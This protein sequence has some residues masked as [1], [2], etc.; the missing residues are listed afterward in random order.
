MFEQIMK[1]YAIA[2]LTAFVTF[3]VYGQQPVVSSISKTFGYTGQSIEISGSGFSTTPSNLIV[4]FGAKNGTVISSTNNFIQ[5]TIPTGATFSSISVTHKVSGLTGFS[6]VKF[7]E[8]F[9]G[10]TTDAI[11]V[12]DRSTFPNTKELFDA[13]IIDLDE[14]GKNDVVASKVSPD[15]VDIVVYRNTTIGS[16]ISFSEQVEYIGNPTAKIG[17]GD[18][19]GDGKV[20]LVLSREG[21]GNRNQISILRN[22]SVSGTISF[23]AAKAYYLP[24]SHLARKVII[25]DMDFDG[26]SEVLVSNTFNNEIS[27][28]KNNSTAGTINLAF[29]PTIIAIDG[30]TKTNGMAVGDINNDGKEDIVVG[31][32]IANDIFVI[33]NESVDGNLIFGTQKTLALEEGHNIA[34][35]DLNLDGNLDILA[36]MPTKQTLAV[37]KNQGGEFNFDAPVILTTGLNGWD[38]GL[39]DYTG[40]GNVDVVVTASSGNTF[41]FYKNISQSGN[42]ELTLTKT[43]IGQT[44][45]TRNA[46]IGD[47]NGD[48][49]PELVMTTFSST[50]SELLVIRN[51]TCIESKLPVEDLTAQI[52]NGQPPYRFDVAPSPDA[53]FIWKK[54]GIEVKNSTDNFYDT[55]VAGTY[56]VTAVSE[57]GACTIESAPFDLTVTTGSI[58]ND[59]VAS[60]SGIACIGSST[61]LFSTPVTGATYLWTGPNGFTSTDQNPTLPSI[62]ADMAGVYSVIAEISPCKSAESTTI[63]EVITPPDFTIVL[64]GPSVLCEGNQISLTV[65]SEVGYSYQWQKDGVDI[66]GAT[67]NV[68]NSTGAGV[69]KAL[70]TSVSCSLSS[71]QVT[72]TTYSA[73]TPSFTTS[74]VLCVDT[75]VSFT[76]TTTLEAGQTPTYTWDFGDGTSSP[77]E[78]P[79][80][81]YTTAQD[82]TVT[83]AVDYVGQTCLGSTP[84]IITIAAPAALTLGVLAPG[85][86]PFC[87]GDSIELEASGDFASYLWSTT[88]T[89]PII[90]VKTADRFIVT[91]TSASGCITIDSIDITTNPQPVIIA[92]TRPDTVQLGQN[93]QLSATGGLSYVWSP[94]DGLDDPLIAEPIASLT[95]TSTYAVIGTDANGCEGTAEVTIVVQDSG[96]ELPVKAAVAFSPNGDGID[97][98]WLIEGIEN[99]PECELVIFDRSGKI[100]YKSQTTGYKND[101]NG[102]DEQGSQLPVGAYFYTISCTNAKTG[103]GSISIIR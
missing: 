30:A 66:A 15:A 36:T 46:A 56:T 84:Q 23:D 28:F 53:T 1:K 25:H 49:K 58:P 34:L 3:S 41:A 76:N 54:S 61:Q 67:T 82:Y 89:T 18:I 31:Q 64:G 35:V 50:S 20:D 38:I 2:I 48:A 19:D 33:P 11:S 42:I 65:A 12:A 27:I 57:S 26:K 83:L 55:D 78:N 68:I 21:S 85:A 95:L 62:T 4:N 43:D 9:P 60:N 86:I 69:Y 52:C 63:V 71:N 16:T 6:A 97:D 10:E 32:F 17:A 39:G 37:F 94:S 77:D 88:E 73:P 51:A 80:H 103:S 29:T 47:L 72:I 8:T 13:V 98:V 99:F 91:G 101:W 22:T 93:A 96:T 24:T 59:P 5:A 45:K 14:D 75:E 81:T 44:L 102:I 70:V 92:T 90:Q 7:Y 100:V 74:T 79:V 87:E 40:N